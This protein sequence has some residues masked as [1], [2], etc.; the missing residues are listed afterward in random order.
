VTASR[1]TVVVYT[2]GACSG[3]PGPGGWAAILSFGGHE[4][5]L[6]GGER[7]TTN[8]RMELQAAIAAL[9]KLSEPCLVR[10]HTDSKY[11]VQ[12]FTER[13]IAG[14]QRRGW[15]TSAKKPVANQD[16]WE[17]L[18]ELARVHTVEWI[19]VRGHANVA[20]NERCDRL[21]VAQRDRHRAA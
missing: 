10:L 8:N 11:L 2:D 16:L 4:R 18:I 1:K 5:E 17:Q 14:W 7:Q 3:N 15:L 20:L 19:W 13:W 12:A 6:S 9:Q 21:A